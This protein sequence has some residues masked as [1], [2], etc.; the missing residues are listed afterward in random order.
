MDKKKALRDI[1]DLYYAYGLHGGRWETEALMDSTA[2]EF[3]ATMV[4]FAE[5][6]N[7]EYDKEL[8]HYIQD[9][10]Y[11]AECYTMDTMGYEIFA[12]VEKKLLDILLNGQVEE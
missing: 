10:E 3:L 9:E 7:V 2:E 11:E 12:L 1:C 5:A 8:S 4:M 6:Y